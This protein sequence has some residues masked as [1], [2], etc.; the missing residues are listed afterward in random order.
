MLDVEEEIKADEITANNTEKTT[1][2]EVKVKNGM[3]GYR[4]KK[5]KVQGDVTREEM[6][7]MRAQAKKDKWS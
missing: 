4:T 2:V 1:I 7:K 3:W 6:V 5:I